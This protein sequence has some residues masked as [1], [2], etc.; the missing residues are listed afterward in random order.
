M[1]NGSLYWL[2]LTFKLFL[3]GID[4]WVK[5]N[6]TQR[7]EPTRLTVNEKCK[8]SNQTNPQHLFPLRALGKGRGVVVIIMIPRFRVG[9]G[10]RR[11]FQ[12]WK[13]TVVECAPR[14]LFYLHEAASGGPAR[15][16]AGHGPP[17]NQGLE[18]ASEPI[19]KVTQRRMSHSGPMPKVWGLVG[20]CSD[21]KAA[22]AMTIHY[23]TLSPKH[24]LNPNAC[25]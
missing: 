11:F 19:L 1:P 14:V 17:S 16:A 9:F 22:M 25:T 13:P 2:V 3:T 20:S 23:R 12:G 4:F 6:F 8:H 18:G 5:F 10:D 24:L 15:S 21:E 7:F